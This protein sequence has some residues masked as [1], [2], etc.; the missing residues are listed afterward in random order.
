[1]KTYDVIVC[2][3]GPAGSIAAR[4]A[5]QKGL[6]VALIEKE[7]LPRHKTCGGGMPSVVKDYLQGLAP[8]SFVEAN[9][10]S[11]RHTWNFKNSSLVPFY[12]ISIWMV[13]RSIF[14]N[15]L[16]NQ[17][18]DSGVDLLDGLAVS[19]IENDS[20]GITVQAGQFNAK[21]RY[22]IGA[23]GAKGQT[24]KTANLCK[25]R[26]NAIAIEVEH[27]HQW[28]SS[29]HELRPD[30]MHLEYGAIPGGYAWIFPKKDHLNVG[31]GIVDKRF[32][33]KNQS[34]RKLIHH[35]ILQY[36]DSLQIPYKPQELTFKAHPVPL[37][38]G[39]EL[40]HT[41]DERILLVGD[42]AGLVNPFFCD[43]IFHAVKSGSIAADC[44]ARDAVREYTRRIHKEFASHFDASQ[45]LAN[46]FFRFPRLFFSKIKHPNY[47]RHAV[48]M[49]CGKTPQLSNP[50]KQWV[51]NLLFGFKSGT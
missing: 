3:A 26:R 1:M 39:Q 44:I 50:F 32:L 13:Q 29:H 37:W 46:I 41:K 40:L 33:G 20:T 25:K 28:S 47:T 12:D 24:I 43:G 31:A 6:R 17:A 4:D 14:D 38:G 15:M 10:S 35:A 7:R 30:V 34:P 51:F 9:V 21:A 22:L 5:A 49:L 16:A 23:D 48:E 42:A 18:A 36:L 45:R 8:S 2:G 11:I 27:P 19:S